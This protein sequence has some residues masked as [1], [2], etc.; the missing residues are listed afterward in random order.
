MH[1]RPVNV[2]QRLRSHKG[3]W[4]LV[5]AAILIKVMTATAC[6]LDG[7]RIVDAAAVVAS[8]T[9]TQAQ[10]I[11][12]QGDDCLL[13]ESGGCHCACAHAMTL[14][15]VAPDVVLAVLPRS[16]ESHPPVT[17][18]VRANASLLRPPIA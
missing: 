11:D 13:G 12:D 16:V 2:I 1:A 8:E 10:T 15:A 9:T 18:V 14:P 3:A 4:M 5:I 17:P 6:M 7:P